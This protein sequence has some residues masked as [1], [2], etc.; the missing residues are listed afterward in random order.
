MIN[1]TQPGAGLRNAG[2]TPDRLQSF[3]GNALQNY[4]YAS[5]NKAAAPTPF[6][7]RLTRRENPLNP[8]SAVVPVTTRGFGT[9]VSSNQ[10]SAAQASARQQNAQVAGRPITT[11]SGWMEKQGLGNSTQIANKI[12]RQGLGSV[13]QYL[14]PAQDWALREGVR[15]D[16]QSGGGIVGFGLKAAPY[17]MSYAAGGF[18]NPL[19]SL[20]SAAKSAGAGAFRSVPNRLIANALSNFTTPAGLARKAQSAVLSRA[21]R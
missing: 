17:I 4:N 21:R 19:T 1:W 11:L 7:P 9:P 12:S 13:Q 20:G 10:L 2:M 15:R 18:G 3:Y 8:A 6:G 14:A 16:V 5:Q